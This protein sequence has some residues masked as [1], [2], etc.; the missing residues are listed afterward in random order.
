MDRIKLGNWD[1]GSS[2]LA[3]WRNWVWK[4]K[5]TKTNKQKEKN[6]VKC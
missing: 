4:K 6:K 3:A 1:S 2:R 5:R